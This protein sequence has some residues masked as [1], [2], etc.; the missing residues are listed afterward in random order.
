[1]IHDLRLAVLGDHGVG[2]QSSG[3]IMGITCFSASRRLFASPIAHFSQLCA[4]GFLH[5]RNHA[6]HRPWPI[7]DAG[8]GVSG[9]AVPLA[10]VSSLSSLLDSKH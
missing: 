7:R 6:F 10:S 4:F 9:L 1:V 8:P 2:C 3:S 5:Q